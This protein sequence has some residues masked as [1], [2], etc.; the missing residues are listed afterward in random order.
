MTAQRGFCC[1]F[2]VRDNWMWQVGVLLTGENCPNGPSHETS[3]RRRHLLIVIH[4]LPPL[5]ICSFPG[6]IVIHNIPFHFILFFFWV[7][8]IQQQQLALHEKCFYEEQVPCMEN[9]FR[10]FWPLLHCWVILCS[11]FAVKQPQIFS[12]SESQYISLRTKIA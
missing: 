9:V 12:C 11:V 8:I 10:M 5:C 1:S 6:H 3:I 4:Q 7:N 2:L